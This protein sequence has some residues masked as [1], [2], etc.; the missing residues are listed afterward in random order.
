[1]SEILT[2]K[3]RAMCNFW[4]FVFSIHQNSICHD[5]DYFCALRYKKFNLWNISAFDRSKELCDTY[6]CFVTYYLSRRRMYLDH[7]LYCKTLCNKKNG[8]AFAFSHF[9]GEKHL[10]IWLVKL[11]WSW[12]KSIYSFYWQSW[13]L[14]LRCVLSQ[15]VT[16]SWLKA[17]NPQK[18]QRYSLDLFCGKS[19]TWQCG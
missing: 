19:S 5:V 3:K 9:F 10:L 1:M 2:Y 11:Y 7:K 4:L 12:F 18:M 17:R 8:L 14:M 16:E 6:F 13:H 15:K